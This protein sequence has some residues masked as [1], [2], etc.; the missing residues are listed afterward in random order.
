MRDRECPARAQSY[1]AWRNRHL[2]STVVA[3]QPEKI[4]GQRAGL[5][6]H[7]AAS[8]TPDA[9]TNVDLDR[10]PVPNHT[11]HWSSR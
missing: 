3:G 9:T 7:G 4:R 1:T 6:G 5:V 2:P 8:L 11:S 10:Y